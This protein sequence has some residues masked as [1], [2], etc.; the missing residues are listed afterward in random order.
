LEEYQEKTLP[1]AEFYGKQ[2]K[3]ATI[4]ALG[5]EESVF[6]RLCTKVEEAMRILR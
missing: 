4:E 5:S 3:F 6:H 1:V 2:Q